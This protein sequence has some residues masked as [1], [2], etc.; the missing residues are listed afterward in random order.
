MKVLFEFL[1]ILIFFVAYKVYDIYVAT[2]TAIVASIIQVL[3]GRLRNGHWEKSQLLTLALITVFGGATLLLQDEVYIKWKPTV[4]NGLFAVA[5]LGSQFIGGKSLA[6][7]MMGQQIQLEAALWTRINLSW[8]GFFVF[9]GLAN[10]FVM[11]HY[12]T[13]TWVNFK[14]FGLL[15]LTLA[16]IIAQSI[17]LTRHLSPALNDEREDR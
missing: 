13:A 12:D 14:L 8:V 6:E 16:F 10:W 15:G 4:L 17:Y 9:C 1:P 2:A 11:R 5:F 3:A 7:R